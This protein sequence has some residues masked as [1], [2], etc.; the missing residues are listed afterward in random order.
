MGHGHLRLSTRLGPLDVLCELQTEGYE[1]LAPHSETL[2]L[3][4]GLEALVVSLA[5]LIE[6]KQAAGRPKDQLALP[7][8]R[9][10]LEELRRRG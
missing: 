4:E 8:L 6:L 10:T 5:R 3:G 1:E 7:I 2:A 9:A